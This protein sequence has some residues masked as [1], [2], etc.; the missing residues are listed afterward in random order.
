MPPRILPIIPVLAVLVGSAVRGADFESER[1]FPLDAGLFW[2]YQQT[3]GALSTETITGVER[4]DGHDTFVSVVAGGAA[5]GTTENLSNGPAG[6]RLHRVHD[7]EAGGT[8]VFDPPV[9]LAPAVGSIGDVSTG[10]GIAGITFTGIGSYSFGYQAQS[11]VVARER[12]DVPLGSFDTVKVVS[13]VTVSGVVPGRGPISIRVS[14][15][16]WYVPRLGAVEF[17]SESIDSKLVATN[18]PEPVSLACDLTALLT[19]ARWRRR[20]R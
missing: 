5:A 4:I 18:A 2:Q 6:L 19:I 15:T 13:D 16:H 8:L 17:E 1:E 9:V 20:R 3:D 10:A 11:T 14:D 7:P 12:R